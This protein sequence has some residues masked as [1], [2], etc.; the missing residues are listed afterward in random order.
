VFLA[1]AAAPAAFAGMY[2]V[3]RHTCSSGIP[4]AFPQWRD[5]PLPH[6]GFAD[7][8]R[9]E[10]M[11]AVSRICTCLEFLGA[12]MDNNQSLVFRVCAAYNA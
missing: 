4:L 12:Y 3:T 2:H 5:G 11:G 6:N 8:L 7:K 10:V 9:W 1:D